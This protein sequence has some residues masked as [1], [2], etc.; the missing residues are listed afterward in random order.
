ML[1]LIERNCPLCMANSFRPLFEKK[2]FC[3]GQCAVCGMVYINPILDEAGISQVYEDYGSSYFTK[4][5]KLEID[6]ASNRFERELRILRGVSGR[7]LDVGCA[8]GSFLVVAKQAGFTNVMGIDIASRSVEYARR[9]GLTACVGDFT[10]SIFLEESFDVV[11]MWA[12]LEHLADP[13]RFILEAYRVLVPG[14]FLCVSVPNKESLTQMILGKKDR[15]VGS[16]HLNY[17]DEKTVRQLLQSGGF[18]VERVETRGI[19]PIVILGDLRSVPVNIERQIHDGKRTLAIKSRRSLGLLRYVHRIVDET[20]HL[21]RRGD[22]L[23]VR[24]RKPFAETDFFVTPVSMT[25]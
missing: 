17:F 16:D 5:E 10:Q 25:Q 7:L 1:P 3:Y 11:T 18:T 15:Y 14:G 19:N 22:L 13:R 4:L 24:A 23:L 8:T 20:L 12:T 21:L 9:I 6:F 2:G